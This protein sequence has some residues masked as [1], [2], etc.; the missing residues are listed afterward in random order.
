MHTAITTLLRRL[1]SPALSETP[2]IQWGSPVPSFGDPLTAPVATLGLNPSNREFV[3]ET[4]RELKGASRRFHTLHSL[5]LPSWSQA[6]SRHLRL[7]A[8]TC[9]TYFAQ[10]PYDRWFGRLEEII[11]GAG[12]S[13]YGDADNG[14]KA[15]HLDLI[16]YATERKWTE[17]TTAEQRKLLEESSDALGILLR[18]SDVKVLVLNGRS[19]VENFETIAQTS[20]HQK[21]MPSWSLPRSKGTDVM[22][23]GFWGRLR[24][25]GRV[26]LGNDLLV[27]GYNHNIQSSFGVTNDVVDRI[28]SWVAQMT[29]V[30]ND[31]LSKSRAC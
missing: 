1:D 7:I 17:L 19:V 18:Q 24:S 21:E 16:P 28:R 10:N 13:F 30:F 3:D 8:K 15:C 25:V 23:V 29:N 22:G 11:E 9:R 12:A 6:N 20:L 4:G 27:L 31:E 2:V 26:H 5:N 14:R